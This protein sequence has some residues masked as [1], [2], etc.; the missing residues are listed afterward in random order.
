MTDFMKTAARDEE[1]SGSDMDDDED[2]GNQ[3]ARGNFS[4]L[5]IDFIPLSLETINHHSDEEDTK[6][7]PKDS[8]ARTYHHEEKKEIRVRER[9]AGERNSPHKDNKKHQKDHYLYRGEEK[10]YESDE[11]QGQG[12]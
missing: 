7:R 3:F 5:A 10:P 2:I 9:P 6:A 8:G 12:I 11:D 1:S 4:F